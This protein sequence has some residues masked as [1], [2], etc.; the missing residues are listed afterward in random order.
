VISLPNS[1]VTERTILIFN[2]SLLRQNAI[3]Y[4][5][6]ITQFG[7]IRIHCAFRF[8]LCVGNFRQKA[9]F[10]VTTCHCDIT[11]V[12]SI[13]PLNKCN[14]IDTMQTAAKLRVGHCSAAKW[15]IDT[16]ASREWVLTVRRNMNRYF[17]RQK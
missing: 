13:V 11:D 17:S 5:F 9:V 12:N 2:K 14:T 1:N 7:L 6:R 16:R 4:T 8:T 3:S 15:Q 10:H